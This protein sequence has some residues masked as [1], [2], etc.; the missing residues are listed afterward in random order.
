MLMDMSLR[1]RLYFFHPMY[2][3]VIL[4]TFLIQ[5]VNP[6]STWWFETI[7]IFY[8]TYLGNDPIGQ[9]YLFQVGGSTTS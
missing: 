1:S 5:Q 9:A 4:P 6:T 7:F 8:C 3:Y 2:I